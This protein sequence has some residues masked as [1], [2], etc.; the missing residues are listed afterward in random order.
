VTGP[1][2]SGGG[3]EIRSI[4]A[5]D[6]F[7]LRR[8]HLRPG[9]PPEASRYPGDDDPAAL[10]LGAFADGEE[11]V[12]VVSFLPHSEQGDP[13]TG[14]YELQAMVT[15]PA[16]RSEGV[17]SILVQEGLA[18]LTAAGAHRVWCDGRTPATSFYERLGFLT[19]GEEFITPATGPHYRFVMD[20]G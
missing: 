15:I 18:R 12:A 7:P 2:T 9:L 5:D 3:P 17:G 20:I 4:S 1:A 13:D 8:H 14:V 16:A 10:H 11:L 6:A 19:V